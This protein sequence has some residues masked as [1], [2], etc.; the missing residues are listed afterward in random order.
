MDCLRSFVINI[1]RVATYTGVNVKTWFV[2]AQEFWMVSDSGTSVYNVQGFKNM[3]IYG[4]DVLGYV[5][6][7]RTAPTSGANVEDW[8]FE[9][10]IDG[11]LPLASGIIQTSPPN[12]WNIEDSTAG[13]RT[14]ALTKNTNSLKFADPIKSAQS[15]NFLQFYSHGSGGQTAGSVALDY[16]LNFIIYY[17]YE[18]E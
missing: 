5:T 9:I 17:K 3:D 18:G 6:T 1:D 15:L 4:I 14:F 8:T 12:Y 10:R 11:Q 2:G 16:S 13:T 7:L